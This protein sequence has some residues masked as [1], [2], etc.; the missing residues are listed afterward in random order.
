MLKPTRPFFGVIAK[1]EIPSQ[2]C[3]EDG[4]M[5]LET[6]KV[7]TLEKSNRNVDVDELTQYQNE[8]DH[9][10]QGINTHKC[11]KTCCGESYILPGG[12]RRFSLDYR[13]LSP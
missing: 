6:G 13:A 11:P 1:R 2:L 7:T 3:Q 5:G 12:S 10:Q 8:F 9:L 4:R